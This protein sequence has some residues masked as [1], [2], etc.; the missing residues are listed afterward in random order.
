[1]SISTWVSLSCCCWRV[2]WNCSNAYRSCTDTI[3]NTLNNIWNQLKVISTQKNIINRAGNSDEWCTQNCP[4]QNCPPKGIS[5]AGNSDIHHFQEPKTKHWR[6][7]QFL[8]TLRKSHQQQQTAAA[9][10]QQVQFSS[11]VWSNSALR[12]VWRLVSY[13][14]RRLVQIVFNSVSDFDVAIS[15]SNFTI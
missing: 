10:R 2:D 1:M 15:F 11:P 7:K 3:Q 5:R 13:F 8:K 4:P 14:A 12:E 6:K 9:G